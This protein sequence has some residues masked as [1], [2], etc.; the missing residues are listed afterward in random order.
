MHRDIKPANVYLCRAGRSHDF[1]KVLDFGLVKQAGF[2]GRD[3]KLTAAN[4]ATGTPAYMAPELALGEDEI[5]G[6]ADLYA[7]G[8]VAYFLLT[9]VQ[10]FDGGS[11][12]K[13]MFAHVRDTPPAPS[14]RTELPIPPALETLVMQCLAKQPGDR[15]QT[16]EDLAMALPDTLEHGAWTEQHAAKWWRQHLPELVV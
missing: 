14:A 7:L 3:S 13:V 16:A 5:D 6:R 9:G 10:V 11:P 1:A 4:V 8:C 15:P 2:A 12:A